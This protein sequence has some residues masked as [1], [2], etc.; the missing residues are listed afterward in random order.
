MSLH[1]RVALVTGGAQGIGRAIAETLAAAGAKVVVS[2]ING[3][4]A[5]AA[6]AAIAAAHGVETTAVAGNVANAGEVAAMVRAATEQL[7]NL[8]IVVNNA[9]IT[10]DALL[11]RMKEGEWDAVLSVNLK[12]AFLVTQAAV[13]PM[14][15]ARWGRIVNIASI[16]GVMGNIGQ[17]N[18]VAAK[19]GLIGLTKTV[20]RE[21][22]GRG[23]TVNAV[24]PG[25]IATAMT[26]V[27][28][29]DVKQ[30]LLSQIPMGTLG[31]AADVAAAVVFLASEEARYITGQVLHVNGG[32]YM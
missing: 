17:A 10:R 26:E 12:G 18:Y 2:D 21:Y 11:L 22:A 13:R 25:F 32:M 1:D 15:K 19:A 20:A 30:N 14:A 3:E 24:A 28:S 29:D 5:A 9:G 16:V 31:S 23:I 6:A 8:H 4:G 27:L 7:G